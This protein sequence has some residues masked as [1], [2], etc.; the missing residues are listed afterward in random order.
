MLLA[1][2]E[3]LGEV[4][5]AMA[6]VHA[7]QH[8]VHAFFALRC[9]ESHVGERQFHVLK[10]VK[11]VNEVERLEHESYLA[12]A[13][14]SALLFL[15]IGHFGVVELVASAGGVVEQSEDVEQR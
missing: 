5:G 10:Y 6:D 1:S 11:L 12:F 8:F 15:K 9:A 13:Q 3:L 2:R 4:L 7:L 14:A